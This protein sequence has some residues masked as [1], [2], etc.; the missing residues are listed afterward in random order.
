MSKRIDIVDG[1]D[2][3]A[4][5]Y[6]LVYTCNLGW[7]DLG[8]MNPKEI[9][10]NVGAA[11]LWRQIKTG[12]PDASAPW[13]GGA[14]VNASCGPAANGV[15]RGQ[16]MPREARKDTVIR[17]P[18]NATGFEVKSIQQMGKKLGFMGTVYANHERSYVVRHNLSEP[19]KQAVALAIFMEVSYGFER[20]QG[21]FPQGL[22]SSDSSFSQEDLVSNLV[23]FYIAVG[24]ITKT[25]ALDAAN[26]ISKSAAL[27]IWDREGSVGSNKNKGFTPM[28]SK[29]TGYDDKQACRDECAIKPRVTPGFFSKIQPANKGSLFMS[30]PRP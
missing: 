2:A 11:A 5:T 6:G 8:H 19:E 10:P 13:C 20:M 25:Q 12:G 17:F 9:R 1:R 28:L 27:A 26:P 29:N 21:K 3:Y 23:G 16:D 14:F 18:D 30:F 24:A 15:H 22:F 7:L 4:K